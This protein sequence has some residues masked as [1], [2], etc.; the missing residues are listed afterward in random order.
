MSA[1]LKDFE[2]YLVNEKHA[3]K[4][5]YLSYIRDISQFEQFLTAECDTD[6]AGAT[7]DDVG[8]YFDKLDMDGKSAATVM[9]AVA[10]LKNFYNRLVLTG[11]ID[12][13]PV[14]VQQTRRKEVHYPEILT[15][16]EVNL[17]LSQPKTVDAK[18]YRD[19]AMLEMLYATG[20]RVTELVSL[21]VEDLNL[22]MG[23]IRCVS[24]DHE[25]IIPLYPAAVDALRSYLLR[26]RKIMTSNPAENSLF[27]NVNGE[28]MTRQ[29]FWKLIK[30]YAAQANIQKDITPHTL[31]HSFAVHLLENGAD[32]HTLQELMGHADSSSTLMYANLIKGRLGSV[33][34]AAHPNSGRAGA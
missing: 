4:N 26:A 34:T 27:V 8:A 7:S 3:S 32:I 25:R 5:T 2:N 28:R 20:M 14:R 31:R 16:A 10:A 13:S 21:N 11:E 17:L 23:F 33:Y 22:D 12:A 1:L 19:R 29:G 24:E 15:S 30:H 9:R 18:G 6:L